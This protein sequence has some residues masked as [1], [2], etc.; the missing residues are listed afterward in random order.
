M[1]AKQKAYNYYIKRCTELNIGVDQYDFDH[2]VDNSLS[3][4]E[5]I[6]ILE[7]TYFNHI[8][9][10]DLKMIKQVKKENE[11]LKKID[12]KERLN[13]EIDEL[14][15]EKETV[16]ELFKTKLSLDLYN[17]VEQLLGLDQ[18]IN[19]KIADYQEIEE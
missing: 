7:E 15:K 6:N 14:Q 12:Y 17:Q 8:E 18:E 1:I 19:N 13:K 9:G 3:Y 4:P 16:L 10:V 2:E 11:Q 5:I